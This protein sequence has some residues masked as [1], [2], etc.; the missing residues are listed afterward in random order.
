MISNRHPRATSRRLAIG[1][2]LGL[3]AGSAIAATGPWP[4]LEVRIDGRDVSRQAQAHLAGGVL[5]LDAAALAP[6]LGI[7]VRVVAGVLTVRDALGRD[8]RCSRGESLLRST[9]RG[10]TLDPPPQFVGS[11]VFLPAEV[12]ADLA[13]WHLAVNP[14]SGAALL[15]PPTAPPPGRRGQ[16][17]IGP[18]PAALRTAP[19]AAAGAAPFVAATAANARQTGPAAHFASTAATNAP[20]AAAFASTTVANP[21]QSAAPVAAFANTAANGPQDAA[22][23]TPA[24]P[25]TEPQVAGP[26]AP[27][28]AAGSTVA[29][30][31]AATAAMATEPQVAGPSAPFAAAGSTVAPQSAAAARP[32]AAAAR[33]KAPA[34]ARFAP[35]TAADDPMGAVADD[36]AATAG[37]RTVALPKPPSAAVA[38]AGVLGGDNPLPDVL[39]PDHDTLLVAAT[40]GY[41][42]GADWGT[43]VDAAGDWGGRTVRAYGVG[44]EGP[45]GAEVR[46]GYAGIDQPGSWGAEGGDLTSAIWGLAQGVRYLSQPW[47]GGRPAFSLYLP[48]PASGLTRQVV[49]GSD[50]VALGHAAAIGGEVASDGSSLLRGHYN[51]QG[52]GLFVFDRQAGGELGPARGASGFA[53]L[54]F[55]AEIQ[56][57][58]E[59]SGSSLLAI[60]SNDGSLR[61]PVSH[62]GGLTL[63]STG[64]NTADVRLRLDAASL[65]ASLG[66]LL[67]RAT[68]QTESGEIVPLAGV[69]SPLGEHDALATLAYLATNRVRLELTAVYRQ[70]LQGAST[71]WQQLAA[72]LRLLSHT[73]LGI[74]VQTPGAPERDPLHLYLEQGLPSGF[75]AFFE[76]GRMPTFQGLGGQDPTGL[77]NPVRFK[78]ALRKVWGVRTPPGGGEVR[79]QVTGAGTEVG[80][81]VPVE[82]GRYRTSTDDDGNFVFHNV[83]PGTYAASVPAASVPASFAGAPPPQPV[84]VLPR[85]RQQLDLPLVPLGTVSGHV[86]LAAGA[87]A[88]PGSSA[89]AAAEAGAA[90]IVVRLDDQ[91]TATDRDGTFSFHEVLPGPHRLSVDE[92]RLP[93]GLLAAPPSAIDLGL[94]AGRSLDG[95]IFRLTPRPRPLVLDRVER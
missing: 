80:N 52:F 55:G 20:P 1:L 68:W 4:S 42:V 49:T 56:G 7:E 23:A 86:L 73:S 91:V 94:P 63:S 57:G 82:L 71:S 45:A 15:T 40:V 36:A 30:Q 11:A 93:H 54:P 81:G 90:G 17:T 64:L 16:P 33:G 19:P 12:V 28:A 2:S 3:L 24:A 29:P 74:V 39:P 75:T 25:A 67:A 83:P 79:G 88:G 78:I 89:A 10:T 58:W 47:A 22:P 18:A 76:V 41:I 44:T 48:T 26:S 27:F 53:A 85:Q 70:P 51:G 6:A 21:A 32:A 92:E 60:A 65:D 14:R 66:P 61:I 34:T 59:E 72:S 84:T 8:W 13:G 62:L 69:R 95:V 5:L 37:W 38:D 77:D 50:D 35:V 46:N 87:G 31:S 43:E 9:G